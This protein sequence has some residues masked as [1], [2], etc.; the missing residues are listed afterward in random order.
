LNVLLLW[1]S[2]ADRAAFDLINKSLTCGL[3]D[4]VMPVLSNPWA[5]A[6]PLGIVWIIFFVRADRNGRYVAIG[7]FVV[8]ALT[9]QVSSALIK[10]DVQRLRPC[11]VVPAAHIFVHGKWLNADS[12][13]TIIYKNSFSFPSGH[14]TNMAGQAMYWTYFYPEIAPVTIT[15]ALLVGYSRVY[16]GHHWPGDVVA[17]YLVG[18]IIAWLMGITMR[19]WLFGSRIR[20]DSINIFSR[21]QA[22]I[23][24]KGNEHAD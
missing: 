13:G 2:S 21:Q 22:R 12:S 7:C 11:N 1:I 19:K 5:W 23:P 17:G 6:V 18:A 16:L 9:D 3:F 20:F 8:V 14:A 4:A 24:S 15:A 10:R